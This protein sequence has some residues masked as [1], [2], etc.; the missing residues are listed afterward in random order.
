[1]GFFTETVT[2][3]WVSGSPL[4]DMNDVVNPITEAIMYAVYNKE[5]IS[6]HIIAA[7]ISG[8]SSNM[9]DLY[10][11]GLL[12]TQTNGAEGYRIGLPN[13]TMYYGDS[14]EAEIESILTTNFGEPCEVTNVMIGALDLDMFGLDK[15]TNMSSWDF[16][17]QIL[18]FNGYVY[19]Y[20]NTR[21]VDGVPNLAEI[22]YVSESSLIEPRE[23]TR[24][25]STPTGLVVYNIIWRKVSEPSNYVRYAIYDPSTHVYPSL[26]LDQETGESGQSEY[27]PIIPIR[28][29]TRNLDLWNAQGG[30]YSEIYETSVIALEMINLKMDDLIDAIMDVEDP[31]DL[32][33][34]SDVFFIFGVS[35]YTQEQ[36]SIDYLFQYFNTLYNRGGITEEMY[37]DSKG[38]IT[39]PS[40]ARVNSILTEDLVY[41]TILEYNFIRKTVVQGSIGSRG[42]YTI[43]HHRIPTTHAQNDFIIPEGDLNPDYY[44]YIYLNSYVLIRYQETDTSYTEIMVHGLVTSTYV[45]LSDT[46]CNAEISENLE[47]QAQGKLFIPLN[48]AV[49][50]TYS[51][52]KS[53]MIMYDSMMLVV[54]SIH[55]ES[56]KWYQSTNFTRILNGISVYFGMYSFGKVLAAAV[57]SLVG[58]AAS[59]VIMTF[60]GKLVI[61]AFILDY[62]VNWILENVD[63]DL[64]L[65][66]AIAL[67]VYSMYA[68]GKAGSGS[69]VDQIFKV[70]SSVVNAY[71]TQQ[72][73]EMAELLGE[74]NK[75]VESYKSEMEG[76][77]EAMDELSSQL[78]IFNPMMFISESPY[79]DSNE[80][81][82]EFYARTLNQ[83]IGSGMV[84]YYFDAS[85]S[86]PLELK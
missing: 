74:Y 52:A 44:L 41:E 16:E 36:D 81:A 11:Y 25:F 64:G 66:L 30:V 27:Y 82:D 69:V 65:I 26:D 9:D 42:S 23:I 8:A 43:S 63:G 3:T 67:S 83:N 60:V 84:D 24:R 37:L 51:A 5:S 22:T 76:I 53:T 68:F 48:K 7:N 28:I 77:N 1:M 55:E 73:T 32:E 57:G 12:G 62:A 38:T 6:D 35:I 14:K 13:G 71:S 58:A 40:E 50:D 72:K 54:Y 33:D 17:N 86:L 10:A 46:Y 19:Y 49:M 85:L 80:S 70:G 78:N 34:I 4:V 2:T 31:D 79:F 75:Q 15:T 20:D 45:Q 59:A 56:L 29:D 61:Q 47:V 39:E 18:Y 21:M